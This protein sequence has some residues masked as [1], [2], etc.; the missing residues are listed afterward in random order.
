VNNLYATPRRLKKE[1]LRFL[2]YFHPGLPA[3]YH[4]T[5]MV[6]LPFNSN[7]LSYFFKLKYSTHA[8]IKLHFNFIL[9][10]KSSLPHE[11][12]HANPCKPFLSSKA[13]LMLLH[14]KV[15]QG[16]YAMNKS[17]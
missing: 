11:F 8:I 1:V 10:D 16:K 9:E 5:Y 12:H 15:E 14:E 6:T 7:L 2:P 4:C 17:G 3:D 13:H